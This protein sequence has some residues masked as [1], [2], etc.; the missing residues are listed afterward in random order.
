MLLEARKVED[1]LLQ[2]LQFAMFVHYR[3]SNGLR[4]HVTN[5]VKIKTKDL[6]DTT[7]AAG[8]AYSKATRLQFSCVNMRAMAFAP[9]TP[10]RLR[11]RLCCVSYKSKCDAGA[12]FNSNTELFSCSNAL[13]IVSA[14]SCPKALSSK[15]CFCLW[16]AV[17]IHTKKEKETHSSLEISL[18]SCLSASAIACAPSTPIW[19]PFKLFQHMSEYQEITMGKTYFNTWTLLFA[20]FNALAMT[21]ALSAPNWLP[22]RLCEKRVS[23]FSQSYKRTSLLEVS[24][25]AVFMHKRRSN[26]LGSVA[27]NV[28]VLKTVK[29]KNELANNIATGERYIQAYSK[30]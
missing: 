12:Y 4:A 5:L 29:K 9:S 25:S 2:S 18:F 11:R 19:F 6:L 3:V 8:H 28:V 7:T 24:H 27:T 16:L 26:G 17:C 10:M 21:L 1:D 15:L 30:V 14:P 23:D 22:A 13:A 20:S